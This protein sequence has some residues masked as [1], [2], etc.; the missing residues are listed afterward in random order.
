[1]KT[2]YEKACEGQYLEKYNRRGNLI[3]TAEQFPSGSWVVHV[4]SYVANDIS[5]E[6]TNSEFTKIR[7]R[8]F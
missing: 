3:R 4:Y 5:G 6:Y 8:Y 1:M 7:K 2:Q